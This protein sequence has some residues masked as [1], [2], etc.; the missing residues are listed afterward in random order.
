MNVTMLATELDQDMCKTLGKL[1]KKDYDSMIQELVV[2]ENKRLEEALQEVS[3]QILSDFHI[4]NMIRILE[5]EDCLLD[6]STP[7]QNGTSMWSVRLAFGVSDMVQEVEIG[8]ENLQ[9]A[10]WKSIQMLVKEY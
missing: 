4:E 3:S 10:L 7:L 6:I 1:N 9:D 8:D 2:C 5:N